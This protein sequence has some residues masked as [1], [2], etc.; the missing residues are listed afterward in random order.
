MPPTRLGNTADREV[1]LP[2]GKLIGGST[3][4]NSQMWVR[5]VRQ[6]F[7]HWAALGCD[8]WGFEKV[9]PFYNAVETDRD[10]GEQDYHGG[11]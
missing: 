1:A 9:L 10:H 8:S 5:G 4:V 11:E 7:A 3:S 2:R 6:D